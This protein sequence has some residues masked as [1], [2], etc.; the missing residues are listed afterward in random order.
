MEFSLSQGTEGGGRIEAQA[1]MEGEII[2]FKE[3]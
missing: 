3:P 1:E 2:Y